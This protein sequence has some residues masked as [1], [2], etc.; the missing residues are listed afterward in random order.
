M[1]ANKAILGATVDDTK[2]TYAAGLTHFTQFCDKHGIDEELR[3]LTDKTL[4]AAFIGEHLGQVSGSTA[5]NWLLGLK[6]WH[7]TKGAPWCGEEQWIQMARKT[8]HKEGVPR[9]CTPHY[10]ITI[11]HLIVL[12][13]A[14]DFSIPFH[15]TVWAVTVI[16]FWAC[17]HLSETTVPSETKFNPKFHVTF[18]VKFH[19]FLQENGSKAVSF[20]IPWTKMTHR[21]GADV[22][23]P[24]LLSDPEGICGLAAFTSHLQ[25]NKD[26]P[27][28][29]SLFGYI[30]DDGKPHHMVKEKFLA[31]C[32][33]IWTQAEI[34]NVLGHS[35]RIGGAVYLL[36]LGIA[37]EY[38]AVLDGW[39]SLT[40]LLYWR[41]L[42]EI[43]PVAIHKAMDLDNVKKA[44]EE[45]RKQNCIT[46]ALIEA[47]ASGLSCK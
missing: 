18:G 21:N 8:A 32:F 41:R 20:H 47:A 25:V 27:D 34:C 36:S 44:I 30:G 29:F 45:F 38:V 35:F 13:R 12:R 31:L 16:T 40:F 10:P 14:L 46:N 33:D 17:Q 6:A 42:I 24:G 43:I 37:P 3:M 19:F 39:T 15:V 5:S 28:S 9:K 26:V 4:V 22:T 1:L 2:E 7:D 11:K 23:I